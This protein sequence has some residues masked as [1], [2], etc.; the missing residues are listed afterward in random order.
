MTA[1]VGFGAMAAAFGAG[2]YAGGASVGSGLL[3][4]RAV[5]WSQCRESMAKIRIAYMVALCLARYCSEDAEY[6]SAYYPYLEL[7]PS[8][9]LCGRACA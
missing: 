7:F 2:E 5:S 6:Y 8:L 4:R 3:L 1:I 9:I